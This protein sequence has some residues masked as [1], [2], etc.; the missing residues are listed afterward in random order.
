MPYSDLVSESHILPLQWLSLSLFPCCS[1]TASLAYEPL[2]QE[3]LPM[4]YLLGVG[5]GISNVSS[6]SQELQ[7]LLRSF[8]SYSCL[9]QGDSNP[10]LSRYR[11][12]LLT[13]DNA[14]GGWRLQELQSK[15]PG[16]WRIIA[17]C[18]SL[19]LNAHSILSVFSD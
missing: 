13:S 14:K 4:L 11:I 17:S 18:L 16:L 19:V 5:G 7:F 1:H 6:N 2:P 12:T 8:P 15:E 10:R 3:I 9:Q